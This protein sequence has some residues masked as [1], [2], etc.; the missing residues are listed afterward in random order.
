MERNIPSLVLIA[1][2]EEIAEDFVEWAGERV[3]LG[4]EG[5]YAEIFAYLFE[6]CARCQ[7]A[8]TSSYNSHINCFYLLTEGGT[9]PHPHHQAHKLPQHFFRRHHIRRADSGDIQMFTRPEAGWLAE[10]RDVRCWSG[11]CVL[12]WDVVGCRCCFCG[13]VIWWMPWWCWC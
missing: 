5:V 9:H 3:V 11:F 4:V 10:D 12:I 13:G 8:H 2:F 7:L 6:F 1:H